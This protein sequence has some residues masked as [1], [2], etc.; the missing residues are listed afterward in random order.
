MIIGISAHELLELKKAGIEKKPLGH[1]FVYRYPPSD[2]MP[3][4]DLKRF[5]GDLDGADLANEEIAFYLHLP[6][7]TKI[8]SYCHYSKQLAGSREIELYTKAAKK[9]ISA[10]RELIKGE[11]K[12][13]S[14]FFGGGTPTLLKAVQL[15]DLLDFLST[16]FGLD[17]S[18]KEVSIESSPE[19]LQEEKL[20]ALREAGFN[21]LSIGVQDFNDAV[22]KQCNRNHRGTQAVQ[23]F[24]SARSA[25]FDN[26]NIDLLYGLPGQAI[27]SW[28]QTMRQISELKPESVTAS[29]LRILPGAKFYNAEKS[30]FPSV[31]QMLSMYKLFVEQML[32]MNYLQ[33]FPYQFVKKGKEMAFLE[34]QWSN[35]SFLGIGQSSCSFIAKW[36]YNNAFP[37]KKYCEAVAGN[38]I[39]AAMGKKLSQKENMIRFAALGLK[40]SGVNREQGGINKKL[41]KEKFG[42]EI[43]EAFKWETQK[44][45]ALELIEEKGNFLRLSEKGLFFHDEI[46]KLFFETGMISQPIG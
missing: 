14:I 6:F 21:R 28:E 33:Q 37:L 16:E 22:L 12:L 24:D 19:T 4:M 13:N 38:K 1:D 35:G 26:I 42:L 34:Q 44:L 46:G 8:C 23:A 3:F 15:Q 43:E 9:E 18:G 30:V 41:F 39:S 31:E 20:F 10:Y 7:C 40:K 36:D 5:I 32:S 11:T 2:K 17:L 45:L 29:D 27:E 25:G